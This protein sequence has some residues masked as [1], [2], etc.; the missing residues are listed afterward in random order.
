MNLPNAAALLDFWFAPET[1]P[2][3]FRKDAAFDARLGERFGALREAAAAGD[4]DDWAQ[5]PEG[6]LALV[7]ALDQLP[8]NLLRDDPRAFATDAKALAVAE[9]AIERGLD[10]RLPD[11]QR[12]MLYMPFMHSESR[13]A[14]E[15]SIE[16]FADPAFA[17]QLDYAQRH[18][19][20]IDRFGRYPHRNAILGRASTPEEVAFLKTP[21][22]GF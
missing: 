15:R 16:L 2:F 14:H 17:N 12:G 19:A 3:W 21:G 1:R 22:S 4:L 9:A 18:K 8:R 7:V 10:R 13:A 5:T 11:D 20:I 6:A